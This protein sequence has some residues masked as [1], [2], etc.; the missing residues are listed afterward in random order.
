MSMEKPSKNNTT[1]I[2]CERCNTVFESRKQFEKHA[3]V[4]SLNAATTCEA[5]PIDTVISKFVSLFK[6]DSSNNLG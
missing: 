4:H 3:Y 2:Y 1:K 6:R 5:C